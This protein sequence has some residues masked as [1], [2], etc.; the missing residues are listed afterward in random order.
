MGGKVLLF[1]QRV[2]QNESLNTETF[3]P[4]KLFTM[5]WTV[6]QDWAGGNVSS[7]FTEHTVVNKNEGK[8]NPKQNKKLFWWTCNTPGNVGEN[9]LGIYGR[10]ELSHLDEFHLVAV[11][12]AMNQKNRPIKSPWVLLLCLQSIPFSVSKAALVD[13]NI[14][15]V[16][17]KILDKGAGKN[18]S[19]LVMWQRVIHKSWLEH[20][21]LWECMHAC[22]HLCS[23][24]YV[25]WYHGTIFYYICNWVYVIA[26]RCAN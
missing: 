12:T 8:K 18:V 23:F 21:L 20:Q 10:F 9:T 3:S 16:H 1:K 22:M 19:I 11:I 26:P 14:A 15:A 2:R 17:A 25:K 5:S 7:A 4:T 6:L 13:Y 24:L